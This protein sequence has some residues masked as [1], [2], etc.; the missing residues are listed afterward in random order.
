MWAQ[1][2]A[3]QLLDLETLNNVGWKSAN[4]SFPGTTKEGG[5]GTCVVRKIEH[6][7]AG[8]R[9]HW[10]EVL[11][12]Q[13]CRPGLPGATKVNVRDPALEV[14]SPVPRLGGGAAYWTSGS[15]ENRERE[16][17]AQQAKRGES[18][19]RYSSIA[20]IEQS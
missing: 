18:E 13:G 8:G 10:V 7:C 9:D 4:R 6:E 20:R 12:R 1:A 16:K 14:C 3:L 15:Q 19:S 5:K 11:A 17:E 2:K